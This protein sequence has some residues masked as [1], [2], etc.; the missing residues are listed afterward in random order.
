MRKSARVILVL[1]VLCSIQTILAAEKTFEVDVR[2]EVKIPMR[3]GVELSANIFLPKAEG[4]YPVILI[5]SP[6]GKGDEKNG[7]GLFYAG[8]GYVVVSQD[9]RGK[10]SS[11]GVWEPFANERN[12]GRDTQ[13]WLLEQ[14]WGA[15]G[16]ATPGGSS[17]GFL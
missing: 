14:P 1:S 4:K 16:I 2:T 9:C 7:D 13:K 6:Y 8:R 15:G 12:D 5:R 10:G 3:D 11:Q 17:G